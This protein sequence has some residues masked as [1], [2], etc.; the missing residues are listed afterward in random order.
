MNFHLMLGEKKMKNSFKTIFS[1]PLALI[2]N[3]LLI[4]VS[5]S[6][7]RLLFI[8]VNHNYF[9]DLTFSHFWEMFRGGLVFDT[10]AILYTN[11][12][13]ILLVLFPFHYKENPK[14]QSVVKWIFVITNMVMIIMNLV[15]TVYF[16]I[17]TDVLLLLF[18]V[19]L[20]MKIIWRG[21]LALNWYDIGI[22]S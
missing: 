2:V 8:W 15:D 14:Y 10:S 13:Y 16:S 5:F 20:P 11:A 18:S 17:P 6:L 3:L 1:A 9:T 21:F 7:C 22:W 12:L 19:N 4:Y